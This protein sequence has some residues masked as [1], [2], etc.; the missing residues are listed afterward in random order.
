MYFAGC[1]TGAYSSEQQ[2]WLDACAYTLGVDAVVSFESTIYYTGFTTSGCHYFDNRAFY[3]MGQ[4]YSGGSAA[5]NAKFDLLAQ[6]F[7]SFGTDSV[8][9]FR[10]GVYIN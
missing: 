9:I 2:G 7:G 6:G 1:S 10:T 8:H 5:N 4:G 3:Y